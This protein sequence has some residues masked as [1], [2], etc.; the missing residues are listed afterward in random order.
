MI[1]NLI[2]F[3]Y[4]IKVETIRK[5]NDDYIFYYNKH[6]YIF[7]KCYE[8]EEKIRYIYNYAHNNS[9]LY[10]T[11]IKNRHN[12]YVSNYNNEY[13]ILMMINFNLNRKLLFEDV[14]NSTKTHISYIGKTNF[15]WTKLWK[16]KIDQVD[17]F[18]NNGNINFDILTLSIINYYLMLSELAIIF[19]NYIN[20]DDFI[21][22]SLCHNRI[23]K[24]TD[25]YSYFSITNL[26]L[27]HKT[28]D[29]G[30]YIK[31]YVYSNRTINID[32]FITINQL[33][34]NE[35]YMLVSRIIFPSYFFDIFDDFVLNN[36]NFNNFYKNF[37]Y[38]DS[39]N[40]NL[41]KII[42]FIIK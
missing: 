39:Y 21:P 28:R 18:V 7:T 20:T 36:R 1:T 6:F 14:N 34:S 40:D 3:L 12:K 15:N 27:D 17:F 35:K 33:S 31:N 38:M 2:S 24:N 37:I 26:L 30:E 25:L 4:D 42:K 8:K 22:L 32:D 10:H 23:M 16:Q 13:Y 5:H 19:Y 41:K 9:N 11:I 29:M